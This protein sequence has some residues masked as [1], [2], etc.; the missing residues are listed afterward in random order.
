MEDVFLKVAELEH[1][2]DKTLNHI[3]VLE[4]A[5]YNLKDKTRKYEKN[6]NFKFFKHFLALFKKRIRYSKRDLFGINCEVI[7]PIILI[8]FGC[9]FWLL[10]QQ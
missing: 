5:K 2:N 8:F 7:F 9:L 3:D 4:K 6:Y 1:E 10:T